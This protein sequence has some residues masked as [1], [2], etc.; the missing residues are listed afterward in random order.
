MVSRLLLM[1]GH[2]GVFIKTQYTKYSIGN[3]FTSNIETDNSLE[4]ISPT[5]LIDFS[6]SDV[7]QPAIPFIE[8]RCTI[9][10]I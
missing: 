5:R 7:S 4:Y 1:S 10:A 2:V 8:D 6:Y 9:I 3:L